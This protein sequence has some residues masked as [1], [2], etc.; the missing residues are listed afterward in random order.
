MFDI[1]DTSEPPIRVDIPAPL[2]RLLQRAFPE[3]A[4]RG[5][6]TYRVERACLAFLRDRGV[7]IDA[8]TAAQV[9]HRRPARRAAPARKRTARSAYGRRRRRR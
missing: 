4:A 3:T 2:D 1:H 8:A 7:S 5:F 6:A 9:S